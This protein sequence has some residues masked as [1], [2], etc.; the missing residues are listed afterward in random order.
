MAREIYR[1]V[2]TIIRTCRPQKS[3]VLA[4]DGPAPL[5]KLVEQRC[6]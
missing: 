2:R 3:V 5:A 6:E 4:M 1:S